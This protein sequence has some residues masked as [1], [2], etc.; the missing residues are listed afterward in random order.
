MPDANE[1]LEFERMEAKANEARQR[2]L[3]LQELEAREETEEEET[4]AVAEDEEIENTRLLAA[5]RDQ[6]EEEG[7]IRQQADEIKNEGATFSHPSLIKYS[8]LLVAL[9][10]PNDAIDILFE[11]TVLG[12]PFAWFA[13]YF[14]S[15]ISILFCWFTDHEQKRA[16]DYMKKI[17]TFQATMISRTR[18]AF[19]MAKFFRKN[20]MIKLVLGAV[21]EIIPF[22]SIFPWSSIAV[23]WAYADERKTY[24]SAGKAGEEVYQ[25]TVEVV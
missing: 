19:R 25:Q 1:Q 12:A 20:P 5:K 16:D 3:E 9:A 18:T 8:I 14:L 17:E 6:E 24:K 7:A 4:A 11:P 15:A 21:A 23:I 22:L 2:E 10:I 13:S